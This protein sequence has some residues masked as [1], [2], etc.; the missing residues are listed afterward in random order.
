MRKLNLN[1][2]EN[3]FTENNRVFLQSSVFRQ[4]SEQIIN[5]LL[6]PIKSDKS[7]EV[8]RYIKT[9][10]NIAT[11]RPQFEQQA[12]DRLKK[13]F[14]GKN[15]ITNGSVRTTIRTAL[16]AW[17]EKTNLLKAD[18]RLVL[19]G[20]GIRCYQRKRNEIF[21]PNQWDELQEDD[22]VLIDDSSYTD[23]PKNEHSV[24]CGISEMNI[25]KIRSFAD[26]ALRR[27]IQSRDAASEYCF[28]S[29]RKR[30]L[31]SLVGACGSPTDLL[32]PIDIAL[33][34]LQSIFQS[35]KRPHSTCECSLDIYNSESNEYLRTFVRDRVISNE[36]L[37]NF[38]RLIPLVTDSI[39][40]YLSGLME[41]END[42]FKGVIDGIVEGIFYRRNPSR[43]SFLDTFMMFVSSNNSQVRSYARSKVNEIHE[44]GEPWMIDRL[45]A[46][47]CYSLKY[48]SYNPDCAYRL[49]LSL[50]GLY[51]AV[52]GSNPKLVSVL[53][54]L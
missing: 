15:I 20:L 49:M 54:E 34:R 21:T 40:D 46:M 27:I 28:T 48:V 7:C 52:L 26:D 5:V 33:D 4:E 9:L 53:I 8:N 32:E 39:L 23:V 45:E 47:A 37:Q 30:T 18:I 22:C 24:D 1:A 50:S 19:E 12:L 29:E 42:H 41:E 44:H 14:E 25:D 2:T 36:E 17:M 35:L 10:S 13:L 11:H 31:R 16:G 6:G 38:L 51:F 3:R 43:K